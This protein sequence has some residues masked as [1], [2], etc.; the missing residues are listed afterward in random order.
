MRRSISIL[1]GTQGVF[2]LM[3]RKVAA[4]SYHVDY[5]G[6][7]HDKQSLS[8]DML[9]IYSDLR[10]AVDEAYVKTTEK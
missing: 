10:K 8:G 3:A 5:V 9:N 7:A 2:E 1:K 6:I 4:G